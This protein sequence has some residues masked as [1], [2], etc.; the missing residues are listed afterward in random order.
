[1]KKV[2]NTKKRKRLKR[3]ELRRHRRHARDA[4]IAQAVAGMIARG[5]C[6]ETLERR[7]A[8]R[9]IGRGE[10]RQLGR[11]AGLLNTEMPAKR[12]DPD[13]SILRRLVSVA[14][15]RTKKLR[16]MFEV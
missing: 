16:A 2:T 8:D 5:R 12:E 15:S 6:A 7:L 14:A 13:G 11:E 4:N 10:M 9:G 3:N 1:M